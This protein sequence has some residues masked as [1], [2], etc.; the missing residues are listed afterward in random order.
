MWKCIKQFFTRQKPDRT[1]LCFFVDDAV[2]KRIENLARNGGHNN[3]SKTL[4][5]AL[6][7]YE[8]VVDECLRGATLMLHRL[9]G[10]TVVLLSREPA[11]PG[12]R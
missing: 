4:T 9:D 7:L 1:K 5:D 3:I 8:L 10:K 6:A 11:Q 2:L 12:P